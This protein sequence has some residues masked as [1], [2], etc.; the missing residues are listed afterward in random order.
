V[1]ADR[2]YIAALPRVLGF[3]LL[4]HLV[5]RYIVDWLY[6]GAAASVSIAGLFHAMHNAMV[7]PTG[8]GVAVMACRKLTSW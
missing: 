8:L 5:S 7:N 4:P 6:H 3:L 1:N 2:D